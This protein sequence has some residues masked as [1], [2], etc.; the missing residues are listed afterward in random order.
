MCH[1]KR[2]LSILEVGGTPAGTSGGQRR[3]P[4]LSV[5]PKLRNT[6]S[7]AARFRQIRQTGKLIGPLNIELPGTGEIDMKLPE[8]KGV[9]PEVNEVIGFAQRRARSA[10]QCRMANKCVYFEFSWKQTEP[11]VDPFSMAARLSAQ[12]NVM[13]V[14]P[15]TWSKEM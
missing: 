1:H 9:C 4:N 7:A 5:V 6:H 11:A 3:S 10:R 2:L 8:V 15:L 14:L 13:V 12:A